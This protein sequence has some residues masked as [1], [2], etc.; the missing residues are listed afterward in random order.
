VVDVGQDQ[1]ATAKRYETK[2]FSRSQRV[3]DFFRIEPGWV[4]VRQTFRKCTNQR[5]L[6]D[7]RQSRNQN[8]ECMVIALQSAPAPTY[9]PAKGSFRLLRKCAIMLL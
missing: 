7:S 4:K 3:P 6:A 9:E 1:L 8:L 2:A 5:G